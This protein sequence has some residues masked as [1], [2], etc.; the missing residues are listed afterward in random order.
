VTG[1]V[2]RDETT[3]RLGGH[4][5]DWHMTWAADDTQLL[6]LCDGTGW[7]G[8]RNAPFNSR[9]YRVLGG[10]EDARFEDLA[11]YPDLVDGTPASRERPRYQGY[12]TL[13]VDGRIYQFLTLITFDRSPEDAW[14]DA[15]F[16]GAK[17]IS[18][19]DAGATWRN[20]DGSSP[21]RWEGWDE[22]GSDTMAFWREPQNA[23]SLLAIVQMGRDYRANTDGYVYIYGTNGVVDG[24]INELVLARVPK[25]RVPD[26]TA[27]EFFAGHR[28]DGGA[29]WTPDIE[30]RGVVH[31][32]P[33][34]RVNEEGLSHSWQPGITYNEPLGLYMMSVWG[35]GVNERSEEFSAPS[36]LGVLVSENAWG[37][38]TQIHEEV[39]WTPLGDQ[40]SRCY[41]PQIAPK[42]V[43]ADGRS[44]WLVWSD[45]QTI[46]GEELE[47]A[48]RRTLE[49]DPSLGEE[50]ARSASTR[51]YYAFNTQRVDL[52]MR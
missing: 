10:P 8:T 35:H 4:G 28:A 24:Q 51:P 9:L 21:V 39:S 13:A 46:E 17:L 52:V 15:R 30:Q 50:L 5:N 37:P 11:G 43:A 12:A 25:D 14:S 31:T 18:S 20:Q 49:R 48:T 6:A 34:G 44:F 40:G 36:Y 1:L 33:R 26:R 22:L 45:F 19:P 38:W 2:R 42:W 23:F 32:F 47:R 27:Y 3:L 16:D 29:G 41:Q 7:P